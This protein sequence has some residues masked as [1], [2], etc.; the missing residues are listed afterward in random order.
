MS[1]FLYKRFALRRKNDYICNSIN[2]NNKKSLSKNFYFI[3]KKNKDEE[4]E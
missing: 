2:K 4:I 1:D 3:R